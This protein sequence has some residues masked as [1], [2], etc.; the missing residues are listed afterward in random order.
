MDALACDHPPYCAETINLT[1]IHP[2][3][4]WFAKL[5][6]DGPLLRDFIRDATPVT[7]AHLVRVIDEIDAR[8]AA[9]LRRRACRRTLAA[10]RSDRMEKIAAAII[11]P[12]STTAFPASGS[13]SPAPSNLPLPPP[14]P[15][16]A[17]TAAAPSSSSTIPDVAWTVPLP[18][19]SRAL[20]DSTAQCNVSVTAVLCDSARVYFDA[21]KLNEAGVFLRAVLMGLCDVAE[22]LALHGV[23]DRN[24][25]HHLLI[26]CMDVGAIERER[27][28]RVPAETPALAAGGGGLSVVVARQRRR[29]REPEQHA[30]A[31]AAAAVSGP[32]ALAESSPVR[33]PCRCGPPGV[34][35]RPLLARR[36]APLLPRT[37]PLMRV[38]C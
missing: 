24:F 25:L 2:Y 7:M 9:A 31:V 8:H 6:V 29:P 19:M 22:Q 1:P 30:L 13:V 38:G 3:T 10:S 36:R 14:P 18:D 17:P 11:K 35:C 34:A 23:F 15:A 37:R 27:S 21:T 20:L 26:Q 5:F 4:M 32:G 33:L 16:A 12:L 28:D